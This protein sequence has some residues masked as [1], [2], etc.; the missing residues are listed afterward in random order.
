MPTSK[1][2][3]RDVKDANAPFK[4]KT[5]LP[6]RQLHYINHNPQRLMLS[7]QFWKYIKGNYHYYSYPEI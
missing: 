2:I 3:N 7:E 4:T 1:V 6:L 5:W